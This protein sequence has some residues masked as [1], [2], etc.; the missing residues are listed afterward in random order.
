MRYLSPR[1]FIISSWRAIGSATVINFVFDKKNTTQV[2]FSINIFE[3]SVIF[4]FCICWLLLFLFCL[5]STGESRGFILPGLCQPTVTV[6][7]IVPAFGFKVAKE[8]RSTQLWWCPHLVT[9]WRKFTYVLSFLCTYDMKL[10]DLHQHFDT[11]LGQT[12]DSTNVNQMHIENVEL[13]REYSVMLNI[14]KTGL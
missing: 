10:D 8:G 1:Q 14:L 12:T 13:D 7:T 3:F 11:L 2:Y 5:F 6:S 4:K 9:F